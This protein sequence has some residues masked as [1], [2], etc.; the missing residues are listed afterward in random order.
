MNSTKAKYRTDLERI[1]PSGSERFLRALC[2]YLAQDLNVKFV[3]EGS[4]IYHNRKL[5]KTA[6]LQVR[7]FAFGLAVANYDVD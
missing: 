4:V 3:R 7:A 1:W 2:N 6:I 5:S